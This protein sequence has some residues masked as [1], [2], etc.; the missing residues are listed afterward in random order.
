MTLAAQNIIT[1]MLRV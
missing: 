1:H